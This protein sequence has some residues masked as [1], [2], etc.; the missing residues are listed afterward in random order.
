MLRDPAWVR[1]Q[2][3]RGFSV[4]TYAYALNNPL[5]YTDRSGLET[6]DERACMEEWEKRDV[7]EHKKCMAKFK[8]K[9]ACLLQKGM[10]WANGMKL[11]SES[12]GDLLERVF[13][14]DA[15]AGPK[16]KPI[17]APIRAPVLR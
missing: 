16:K 4:P 1:R 15:G 9:D 6:D 5:R 2:A 3:A 12:K 7:P 13:A 14:P 17:H 10:R 11:C 8:S